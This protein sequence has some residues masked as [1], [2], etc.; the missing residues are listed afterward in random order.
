MTMPDADLQAVAKAATEL[1]QKVSALDEH[2]TIAQQQ[3]DRIE[4]QARRTSR[5]TK[6]L[7]VALVLTVAG[8]ITTVALLVAVAHQADTNHKTQVQTCE[9]GNDSRQ[10]AKATW[11]FF[12]DLIAPSPTAQEKAIIKTFEDYLGHVYAPRDC[13]HLGTAPTIPPAPTL[14]SH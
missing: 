4:R 9:T 8:L 10:A 1:S 3:T 5:L 14:P 7:A 11:F 12:I 6:A 2:L 13:S